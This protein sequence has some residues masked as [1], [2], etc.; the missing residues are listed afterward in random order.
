MKHIRW[1]LVLV[2]LALISACG[3]GAPNELT[4]P[5]PTATPIVY[6]PTFTPGIPDTPEPTVTPTST[7]VPP[8]RTPDADTQ[9]VSAAFVRTARLG[10]YRVNL[11]VT[12]V[13]PFGTRAGANANEPFTALQVEGRLSQNDSDWHISGQE[14]VSLGGDATRGF[15]LRTV[16]GSVFIQGP[17]SRLGAPEARWY[18]S[19]LA[20]DAAQNQYPQTLFTK[21]ADAA[22][23]FPTFAPIE[24]LTLNDRACTKYSSDQGE[25]GAFISTMLSPLPQPPGGKRADALFVTVCNDG[26]VY[27]WEWYYEISDP[28]RPDI[29]LTSTTIMQLSELKIL[30]PPQVPPDTIPVQNDVPLPEPGIFPFPKPTTTS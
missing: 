18:T 22:A 26:Y 27:Q 7:M 24:L 5:P 9:I 6:P 19:A 13:D 20:P 11:T 14:A 29:K 10:A 15:D 3:G 2:A 30:V 25:T 23:V 4:P 17:A 21:F 12:V 16:G 28:N 8:T 1:L